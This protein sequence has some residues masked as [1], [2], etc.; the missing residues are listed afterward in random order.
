MRKST[1]VSDKSVEWSVC[2]FVLICAIEKKEI[3]NET[4]QKENIEN[5]SM[6]NDIKNHLNGKL[7]QFSVILS[8]VINDIERE[9]KLFVVCVHVTNK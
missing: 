4:K 7:N 1:Y 8:K 9:I 3:G 6:K 2:L 5:Y